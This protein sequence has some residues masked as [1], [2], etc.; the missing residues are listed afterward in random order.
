MLQV[1][2]FIAFHFVSAFRSLHF[3][4]FILLP[5]T[6]L[7]LHSLQPLL[8]THSNSN[9]VPHCPCFFPT[10]INSYALFF[11]SCLALSNATRSWLEF[12]FFLFFFETRKRKW[13]FSSI[14]Q[15]EAK[16]CSQKSAR[17]ALRFSS[18]A[19]R[20]L[21]KNLPLFLSCQGFANL[22][23][24]SEYFSCKKPCLPYPRCILTAYRWSIVVFC[25]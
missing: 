20:F 13:K 17:S 12:F 8:A 16:I 25:H 14:V 11:I 15:R 6:T 23:R 19:Y 22:A 4:P 18:F 9:F 21:Q 10:H 24:N 1:A 2:L 7:Q 3:V 5:S